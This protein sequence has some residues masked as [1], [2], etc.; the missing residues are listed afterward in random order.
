MFYREDPPFRDRREAGA[1]LAELLGEYRDKS[2]VVFALPRGGVPVGAEVA[3]ALGAPLD[4]IVARKLGAPGQPELGIGAV[5]PGGVRVLNESAIKRLG[6]PES[7]LKS[8]TERELREVERRLRL[9][10]EGRPEPDVRGKTAILVDDG[11]ATGVTVFAA[12]AYL[13]PRG[14]K[15]IVLAVPVCAA[16]TAERIRPEVDR[17]VCLETPSDLGAIGF[18]YRDFEQVP[19]EAVISGLRSFRQD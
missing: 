16:Q 2:P 10:R 18:W 14:P 13:R 12:I 3:S 5:A 6:I 7:Y 8:V 15:S 19:D 4:V 1:R 17:L 11:L 9:F